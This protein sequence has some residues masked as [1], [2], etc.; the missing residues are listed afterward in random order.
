MINPIPIPDLEP[1]PLIPFF[2]NEDKEDFPREEYEEEEEY[3]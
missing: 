3:D 2:D 1:E